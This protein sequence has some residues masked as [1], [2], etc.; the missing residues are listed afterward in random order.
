MQFDGKG[1]P[2]QHVAHFIET[3]NNARM[4]GDYLLER[5]F[6][7]RFYSMHRTVSM[8]ELTSTKQWKDEPMVDYINRWHSLSLDCKDRL[9][10][11]STIEMCVQ[12]MHWRLHYILQGIKPRTF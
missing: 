2:K 9:S 12:G 3:R 5:E 11:T 7:N 6:L 8:L 4:E 1:N 10:E